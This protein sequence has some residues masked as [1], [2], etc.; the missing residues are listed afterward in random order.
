[1]H[2][3]RNRP[4]LQFSALSCRHLHSDDPLLDWGVRILTALS[5]YYL[6]PSSRLFLLFLFAP[7]PPLS[8]D[9]SALVDLCLSSSSLIIRHTSCRWP[10]QQPTVPAKGF[11]LLRFYCGHYCTIFTVYA[12][13]GHLALLCASSKEVFGI[14]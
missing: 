1:M 10:G 3:G 14:L 8:H 7:S 11:A 9:A 5:I 6:T 13:L 12:I 4:A 2:T